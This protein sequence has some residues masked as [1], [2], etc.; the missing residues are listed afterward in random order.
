MKEKKQL[1]H[2]ETQTAQSKILKFKN[3]VSYFLSCKTHIRAFMDI[4]QFKLP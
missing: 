3:I 2:K 1:K 4:I